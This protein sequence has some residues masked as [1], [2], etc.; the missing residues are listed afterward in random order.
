[1]FIEF[2]IDID[3]GHGFIGSHLFRMLKAE[4]AIWATTQDIKYTSKL[5]KN[6]FRLAF[7]DDRHYTIFRLTWQDLPYIEYQLIDRMW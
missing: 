6:T 1:M 2:K 3:P 5:Y 7:D 4:I